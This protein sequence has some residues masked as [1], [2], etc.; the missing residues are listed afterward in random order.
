V[1][2][3]TDPHVLSEWRDALA[4]A[5]APDPIATGEAA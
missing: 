2:A 5:S 1:G 3:E 4:T